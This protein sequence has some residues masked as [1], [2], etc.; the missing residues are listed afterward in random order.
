MPACVPRPCKVSVEARR[1]HCIPYHWDYRRVRNCSMGAGNQAPPS[2]RA[3]ASALNLRV[4]PLS[5]PPAFASPFCDLD[6]TAPPVVFCGRCLRSEMPPPGPTVSL[7][8][9]AIVLLALWEAP[10]TLSSEGWEGHFQGQSP[11]AGCT[12]RQLLP[13]PRQ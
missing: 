7:G 6:G 12:S 11:G 2:A 10:G 8:E 5:C 13:G 3:A 9:R 4:I 1:G